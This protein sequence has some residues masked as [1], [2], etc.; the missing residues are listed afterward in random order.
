MK[1]LSLML[2]NQI[3]LLFDLDIF[4]FNSSYYTISV[5]LSISI[6]AIFLPLSI[7]VANRLSDKYQSDVLQEIF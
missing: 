2:Q 7:E 1:E 4:S 3:A 6:L 5:S